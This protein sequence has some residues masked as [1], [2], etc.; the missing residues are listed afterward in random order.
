MEHTNTLI[1][2]Y[3]S[4]NISFEE[5]SILLKWLE[6]SDENKIYFRSLKDTFDLGLL[7]ANAKESMVKEQWEKFLKTQTPAYHKKTAIVFIR[8]AAIF[9]LAFFSLQLFNYL[10]NYSTNESPV[11]TK[12]ETGAGDKSK[13]TLPDGSMVWINACSSITYDDQFGKTTRPI[14]LDG[15]AFFEVKTDIEKPF[16]VQA[17]DFTY[18]VTGTSFNVY[19]YNNDS[20]MSIALL[21][22]GVT[23][24]YDNRSVKLHPGEV[25]S[26][27]KTTN[28]ITIRKHDVNLIS[29]WRHGEFIFEN[30]TFE[31]LSKRLERMFDVHFVFENKE[32]IKETYGGT[33]RY[34]DSFETIMTVIKTSNP[35]LKYHIKENTIYIK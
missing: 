29:S 2:K 30:M 8:Y 24:E 35:K 5:Q 13:I 32:M 20:E 16:L 10:K 25:L 3:L 33:L 6:E 27:N 21:E 19:S 18:R 11:I 14:Q 23:V 15:E 34:Y 7:E 22:G 26:Y 17:K 31:E 12:V 28:R 4:K 1:I 9:V